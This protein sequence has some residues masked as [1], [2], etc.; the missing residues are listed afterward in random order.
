MHFFKIFA[1][2][3]LFTAQRKWAE[4]QT[5]GEF[6]RAK[7]TLDALVRALQELPHAHTALV[8]VRHA[9]GSSAHELDAEVSLSIADKD[10]VL[11]VELKKTVYPRD[12]RQILWQLNH[13]RN[14]YATNRKQDVVAL[15]AAESIS[16]GA[17]DLLRAE[18]VG[19]F[20]RGGSLF[21][22]AKGAYL[23]V[24]RPV[25]KTLEKSI[26]SL[27]T[28]KRS[29]V[30]HALL[31][32]HRHWVGVTELSKMAEVSPG[33]ASETLTALEQ[34][35]WVSTRGQ[36][37]AKERCLADPSGLLDEWQTQVQTSRRSLTRR[38]YY[39]PG[40]DA[41]TLAHR[42][43]SLCDA[44]GVEY[45]LTQDA[46]AQ[47]YAPFLSS[48]SRVA[49]RVAPG[50]AAG[51]VLANLEA[52]VVTEG[53]NLDIIETVSRSEFLFKEQKERLW[54]ASPVQVYLDLLRNEGRSRDMA[55]HLRKE[56]LGI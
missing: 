32:R 52:R 56:V 41:D 42:L 48:I 19:F 13:A 12:V 24:E 53:A 8:S 5:R 20:D 31:V 25:P 17:R 50:K 15:I 47:H 7:E 37:P 10:V 55:D 39:V 40:T 49:C 1:I 36:G 22:P 4:M 33:T 44:T 30:L 2:M 21:V 46:A 23:Y 35:E 9:L 29:Q 26:R 3:P 6:E 28:G 38:R 18:N 43:A 16:V 51:D 34:M 14:E 45:V 54:L 27:F 11:L